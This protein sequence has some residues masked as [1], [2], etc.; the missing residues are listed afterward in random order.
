MLAPV[1]TQALPDLTLLPQLRLR[2][3]RA[4]TPAEHPERVVLRRQVAHDSLQSTRVVVG[5]SFK[6]GFHRGDFAF[7]RVHLEQRVEKVPGEDVQA[8]L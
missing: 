3:R 6:L 2:Q 8:F 7:H 5:D 1:L 4:V